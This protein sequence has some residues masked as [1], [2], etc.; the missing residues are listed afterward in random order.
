MKNEKLSSYALTVIFL[1]IFLFMLYCNL[2]T[3]LLTD[4]YAYF[5]D[6]VDCIMKLDT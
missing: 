4:D 6:L 3:G 5:F 2:H 1:I